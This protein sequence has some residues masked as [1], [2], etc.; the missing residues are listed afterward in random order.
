MGGREGVW[1]HERGDKWEKDEKEEEEEAQY[2]RQ[3]RLRD[4]VC[5]NDPIRLREEM[6]SGAALSL[7]DASDG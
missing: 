6:P 2:H 1:A 7:A 5:V 3:P 4:C